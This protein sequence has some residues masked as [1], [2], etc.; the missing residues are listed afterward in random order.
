MFGF[1]MKRDKNKQIDIFAHAGLSG[2]FLAECGVHF[3]FQYSTQN[4]L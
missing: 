4:G 2:Q 1:T 3:K